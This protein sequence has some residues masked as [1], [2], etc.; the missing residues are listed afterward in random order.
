MNSIM[1]TMENKNTSEYAMFEIS[2][3]GSI[4]I[5]EVELDLTPTQ[6]SHSLKLESVDE[7]INS[8]ISVRNAINKESQIK[9]NH[10]KIQK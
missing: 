2:N 3:D 1:F 6:F 4:N 9:I 5:Y 8:L 7:L 10:S